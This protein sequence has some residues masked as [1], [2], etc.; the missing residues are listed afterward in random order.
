LQG[1][2]V[3]SFVRRFGQSFKPAYGLQNFKEQTFAQYLMETNLKLSEAKP[4]LDSYGKP[5]RPYKIIAGLRVSEQTDSPIR[6]EIVRLGINLPLIQQQIMGV[7]L[8]DEQYYRL[9]EILGEIKRGG[10]DI[11]DI[12]ND[13]ISK[14]NYQKLP[15]EAKRQVILQIYKAFVDE[16][17]AKLLQEYPELK[18]KIAQEKTQPKQEPQYPDV[19]ESSWQNFFENTLPNWKEAK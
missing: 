1:Q 13:T 3:E 9:K 7:K 19:F 4:K 10:K 2:G 14:P 18:L 15:Q 16:A 12:L 6:K 17:K 8:T 5:I 11:E